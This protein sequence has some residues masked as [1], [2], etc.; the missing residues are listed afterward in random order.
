M[1]KKIENELVDLIS[2]FKID[3]TMD[4]FNT[5]IYFKFTNKFDLTEYEYKID[6]WEIQNE[7]VRAI[8]M[9]SELNQIKIETERNYKLGQILH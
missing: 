1:S 5:E 4:H 9:I 3:T 8:Q 6:F 7:D 2:V